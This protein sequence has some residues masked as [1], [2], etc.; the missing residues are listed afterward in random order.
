[1]MNLVFPTRIQLMNFHLKGNKALT[2]SE[3]TFQDSLTVHHFFLMCLCLRISFCCFDNM[4]VYICECVRV[5]V[6]ACMRFLCECLHACQCVYVCVWMCEC[7]HTCVCV[8]VMCM[9]VNVQVCVCSQKSEP[10]VVVHL[11]FWEDPWLSPRTCRFSC[12]GWQMGPR[13]C[14]SGLL[15]AC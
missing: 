4:C 11:V 12:V 1:M 9:S 14:R 6:L 5:R 2:F 3:Y 13:I 10:G 8:C 7:L 15:P